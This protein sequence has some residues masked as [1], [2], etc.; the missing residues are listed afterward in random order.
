LNPFFIIRIWTAGKLVSI[1]GDWHRYNLKRKVAALPIVSVE[2]FQKRKEAHEVQL[3][4]RNHCTWDWE[5][6][7]PQGPHTV[8]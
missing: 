4:V 3:K 5:V 1:V 8:T 2:E 7:V 6:L